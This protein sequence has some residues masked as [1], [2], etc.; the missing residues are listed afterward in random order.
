MLTVQINT[1]PMDI[2]IDLETLT[3]TEHITLEVES[4]SSSCVYL[5]PRGVF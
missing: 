5:L 4:Y 3:V 2:Q 1:F